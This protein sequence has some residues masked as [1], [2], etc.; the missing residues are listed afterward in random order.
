MKSVGLDM[1]KVG[2][3]LT[4]FSLNNDG[5]MNRSTQHYSKYFS[6][7]SDSSRQQVV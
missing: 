1:Q 2:A 4:V 7:S 6:T 5:T 3:V